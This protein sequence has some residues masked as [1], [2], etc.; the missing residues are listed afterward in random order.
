MFFPISPCPTSD[1]TRSFRSPGSRPG[2]VEMLR[3]HFSGENR[4]A[5]AYC[6]ILSHRHLPYVQFVFRQDQGS[7]VGSVVQMIEHCGSAAE[8]YSLDN[9]KS[10]IVKPD[11]W[12]AQINRALAEWQGGRFLS[13]RERPGS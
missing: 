11:L 1:S 9:L 8:L 10:E 6:G 7:F 2:K 5:W 13:A 12:D 4:I 3:E